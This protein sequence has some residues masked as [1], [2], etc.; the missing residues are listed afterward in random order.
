MYYLSIPSIG[1]AKKPSKVEVLA[2]I[3]NFQFPLLGSP[4]GALLNIS[5]A[6][7]FQFPLL[8]SNRKT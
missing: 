1:F 5:P 3:N 8:G 4:L 2:D 7:H 6:R